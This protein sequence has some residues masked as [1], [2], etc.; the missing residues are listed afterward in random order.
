MLGLGCAALFG[1]PSIPHAL[2]LELALREI[3]PE[4]L[5]FF[6]PVDQ[7]GDRAS[8]ACNRL[9]LSGVLPHRHHPLLAQYRLLQKGMQS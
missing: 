4:L 9:K 8:E 7:H 5:T 6:A 3:R 2:I 1:V